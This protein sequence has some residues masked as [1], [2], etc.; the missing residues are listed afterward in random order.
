M[1]K[2]AKV[3][4]HPEQFLTKLEQHVIGQLDKAV[5]ILQAHIVRSL[6]AVDYPPASKP[7]EVPH[8]RT[9]HLAQ[10]ISFDAPHPFTRRVGLGVGGVPMVDYGV[11]LEFGTGPHK[12]LGGRFETRK[13]QYVTK[14]GKVRNRRKRVLVGGYNV[15]GET[16]EG[17]GLGAGDGSMLPRPFIRPAV[18]QNRNVIKALFSEPMR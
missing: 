11:Y 13:I 2:K 6:I 18:W 15:R 5:V 14:K 10:S 9:G 4:F 1:N 17:R 12:T 16:G 7:G 3:N 8:H